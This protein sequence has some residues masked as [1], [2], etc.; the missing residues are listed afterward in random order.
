MGR[1]RHNTDMETDSDTDVVRPPQPGVTVVQ[2]YKTRPCHRVQH[3][4]LLSVSL[5][6][7]KFA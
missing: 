3:N 4:L 2:V 1:N 7:P 5:V 6:V